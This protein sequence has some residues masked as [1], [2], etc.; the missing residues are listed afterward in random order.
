MNTDD[1]EA[2]VL[3]A[4]EFK[5]NYFPI[6]TLDQLGLPDFGVFHM[7][8]LEA[9]EKVATDMWFSGE[10]SEIKEPENW[11]GNENDPTFRLLLS[12]KFVYVE[13]RLISAV[14]SGK[15]FAVKQSRNLDEELISKDT[16][17]KY[18]DLYDWLLE[19]GYKCGDILE[20][21]G[22]RESEISLRI[23]DE[24]AYLRAII[25]RGKREYQGLSF[26]S[27]R[28][29]I[30]VIEESETA[31]AITACKALIIENQQLKQLLDQERSNLQGKVDRPITIRQRRTLLTIIAGLCHSSRI[32][33]A[34]RDTPGKLS[35]MT[36]MIGATITDETV[37]KLLGEIPDALESKL[38]AE[39]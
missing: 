36:K 37:K 1:Q 33:T 17:I 4:E 35:D 8:I 22:D 12:E 21:W 5:N 24:L 39:R 23:C 32:D 26:E 13:M 29:K 30:G 27:M 20:S 18:Q 19:R 25:S 14:D 6:D 10:F 15:L 31:D 34:G 16:Y 11:D 2:G 3:S 9:A 7:S 38:A 28:A